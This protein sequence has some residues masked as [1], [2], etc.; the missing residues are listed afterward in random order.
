MTSTPLANTAALPEF[1]SG[2][3]EM[4]R[5]IREYD[6]LQTPLGA[7]QFWP[8]SLKTCVR[9]L[10]TSPQPMF[11]WWGKDTLINIYNDAY[12]FILGDKHPAAL[13]QP[14]NLVWKEIWDTVGARAAI[15][16]TKNEGT[17]DD[18]LPLVLNRYGYDEQTYFK[19]SYNPIPGDGGETGGL[20]CVC[21]E[22]T[23]QVADR[24]KLEE[25]NQLVQRFILQAPVAMCLYRGQNYVVEVINQKLLEI[26]GKS[27]DEAINKP[28]FEVMPEAKEQGFE[29]LLDRV[30]ITGERFAANGISIT[31][32]H[33]TEKKTIYVNLL[34][35]A[36]R[37]SD[38]TIS[39]IV[40][41]ANDVTEQ[42]LARKKLEESEKRFRNLADESP[43]F[44][45]IIE[46]DSNAPVSY[47]NKTW[48]H[49]TGQTAEEAMGRAWDGIIH[50]DDVPVVMEFYVPA[51]Q[52]RQP[53]F[54]PAVRVLRHDGVYRWH[55]FKGNP[56]YRDNGE[57]NGYIGVGIDVH[58]QKLAEE[59]VKRFK[60]MA[61]NASDAFILMRESGTFS[62]L[63]KMALV[64]WGYSP[65]E[66]QQLRVP[67]VDPIYNDDLFA[68]A[69]AKAQKETIPPFETLHKRKDGTIYPVEVSMGG[70]L[71]EDEPHL[72]AVARDITE[73]KEAEAVIKES[74]EQLEFAIDAA[75][76]ATWD[77]NPI[78]N[79]F[80]ADDRYADWFG[81]TAKEATDNNIAISIIAAEDRQRVIAAYT[82]ALVYGTGNTY[83]IIYTIRPSN[84][85]ERI[86]RAKGKAWFGEDKVAYRF[87]GTL[88]DVTKEIIAQKNIE[89]S[90]QRFA[91]A[92]DAVQ[93]ILWTNNARGEMEGEQ[94]GW[95][96]LTGQSFE[97][98]QGYGWSK[99]VHPDD[100]R[101]TVDAW[102]E[103]VAEK[104]TF[105]FEHRVKKI[106][107]SWGQFSI[108]ALPLLN[109]DGSI[110]EWVGVHTE[111][112]KQREA[113]ALLKES[114][115][116]FRTLVETLPQFVWITGPLGER[117]YTSRQWV[118][119]SGMEVTDES[120]KE[121]VHPNDWN[122]VM[123]AWAHSL[124][125]GDK[126]GY[127][128]RIKNKFGDFRWFY[129]S[130][131]PIKD[132]AG[133]TL[134]WTGVV[135][136]IHEQKTRA[137]E[138]EKLVAERTAEL[139]R[140]NE[141]LHQFAHVASHDLKEP[142]RKI[143]TFSTRLEE[144]IKPYLNESGKLY[145]EKVYSATDRMYA[146]IDG[147]LAYSTADASQQ[148]INRVDLAKLIQS[149]ETDVEVA[150][151]LKDATIVC[152]SLPIIEG[153]EV[154]LYQL[155]YNLINNSLKF[156]KPNVKP[157]INVNAEIT[158]RDEASAVIIVKD[159]G[160]GFDPEYA[161]KIFETFTRLNS[162]NQFE[163]TGLGLSLCKKIVQ[164]HH[165]SIE[166][167]GEV[168]VGA[169]FIITLPLRQ[170][171]VLI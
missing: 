149:I 20:F 137:Q 148:P 122:G 58:E 4:G 113:E 75:E 85:P 66:A 49:Y 95:A 48:L 146:M 51:F 34:Y 115:S 27:F 55:S 104:K 101:P 79:Q 127:E 78:T 57:F 163:G 90:K 80:T 50:P 119:Y 24:K 141:S 31:L 106:D 150:V 47:W 43:L 14:A 37:E 19:F 68:A 63:N 145:F 76:L 161:E 73:R 144:E 64:K 162:R 91:A 123:D 135:T 129:T 36:Y 143:R 109:E 105:I 93:G 69:F 56:R 81:I 67:D 86:L 103:A 121:M 39:G 59:E 130:G 94:P 116:R 110:R 97:A 33:G 77:F 15:V 22:E 96:A 25:S 170:T 158:N 160:I 152:G 153:A 111:V 84:R 5:R 72:F 134:Q 41:V 28:L 155:F 71:L 10:L 164:R 132:D 3:G 52:A 154:L 13:G 74:K 117:L 92:V 62:Y 124:S 65:K 108:R 126:L 131:S 7:P 140:S 11:V 125:T 133:T 99:A 30:Y 118:D 171:Q 114:E 136:D 156:T 159:N 12:S 142:V 23:A 8:Q 100:A 168:N 70:L 46:P 138:L 61:D 9:I 16:F 83:D 167:K 40:E 21:T 35:E 1:L 38:G 107:G 102:N 98:Y 44:V 29:H 82:N 60:Y 6:W 54:I 42:V 166:A 157:V 147:V 87:N 128:L 53:Y 165:G 89:E 169:T 26:W 112:T 120:W 151:N 32:P 18:A 139:R 17:F 88:Q 45:F 2:G